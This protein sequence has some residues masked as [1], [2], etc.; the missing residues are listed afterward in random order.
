MGQILADI[1]LAIVVTAAVLC[2]C[3]RVKAA[4]RNYLKGHNKDDDP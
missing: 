4:C 1:L 3:G 2:L